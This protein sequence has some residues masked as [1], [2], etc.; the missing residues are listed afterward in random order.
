MSRISTSAASIEVTGSEMTGAIGKQPDTSWLSV[1]W[2]ARHS[3]A[4]RILNVDLLTC[5]LALLLPWTTTGVAIVAALWVIAF[6]FA[7]EPRPFVRSLARPASM[8]SIAL[9]VMALAGTLWSDA[10]WTLRLHGVGPSLKFLV[11]PML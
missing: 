8:L 9:F 6:G 1:I 2:S 7:L 5:L 10:P 4:A 3:D 11:L